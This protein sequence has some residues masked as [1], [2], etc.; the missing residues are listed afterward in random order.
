MTE[1]EQCKCLT[2]SYKCFLLWFNLRKVNI[3]ELFLKI[4]GGMN[5]GSLAPMFLSLFTSEGS[6]WM[7]SFLYIP[8]HLR[9]V[10][11]QGRSRRHWQDLLARE[12]LSIFAWI[13]RRNINGNH[14]KLLLFPSQLIKA[15]WKSSG[16]KALWK[17]IIPR[18]FIS[19][20]RNNWQFLVLLK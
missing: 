5:S 4:M 18:G 1:A 11:K 13:Y 2:L 7:W 17:A 16:R 10:H 20:W 6:P 19:L 9:C 8:K 3:K 15:L 14:A 12:T